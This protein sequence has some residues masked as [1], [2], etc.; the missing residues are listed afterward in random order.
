MWMPEGAPAFDIER[1]LSGSAYDGLG[2]GTVLNF[3]AM[4]DGS[5]TNT[6]PSCRNGGCAPL[7]R[8]SV[9]LLQRRHSTFAAN[10]AR[11]ADANFADRPDAA[12]G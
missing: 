1:L 9:D 11:E 5:T 2:S 4:S 6:G 8:H 7:N 10:R 3:A 12:V